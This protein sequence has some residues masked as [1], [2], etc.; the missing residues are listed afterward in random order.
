M[1]D[2]RALHLNMVGAYTGAEGKVVR[3]GVQDSLLEP[4]RGRP[5]PGVQLDLIATDLMIEAICAVEGIGAGTRREV[6]W[7]ILHAYTHHRGQL[8]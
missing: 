7:Q 5:N 8:A 1:A 2:A 3:R 6:A 4:G